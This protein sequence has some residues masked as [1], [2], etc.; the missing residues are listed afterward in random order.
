MHIDALAG[1]LESFDIHE[2]TEFY[3]EVHK[4][5]Y[6]KLP[7]AMKWSEIHDMME[8]IDCENITCLTSKPMALLGDRQDFELEIDMLSCR[9]KGTVLVGDSE[10]PRSQFDYDLR[11]FIA[12][13]KDATGNDR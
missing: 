12:R 6:V 9:W 1:K 13:L 5:F 11:S 2:D 10:E 3:I 4:E 8:F 7:R